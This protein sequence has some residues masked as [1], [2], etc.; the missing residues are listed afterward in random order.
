MDHTRFSFIVR[1]GFCS[2]LS[3]GDGFTGF[4]RRDGEREWGGRLE[5]DSGSP[6]HARLDP[7]AKN[8]PLVFPGAFSPSRP[9]PALSLREWR[10]RHHVVRVRLTDERRPPA[11]AAAA[12]T[13]FGDVQRTHAPLLQPSHTTHT[14]TSSSTSSLVTRVRVGEGSVHAAAGRPHREKRGTAWGH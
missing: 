3:P 11:R 4:S 5:R 14:G 10:P 9:T 7:R 12:L 13:H 6:S 1:S 8:A 2:R